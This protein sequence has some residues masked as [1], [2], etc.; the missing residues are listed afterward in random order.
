MCNV[1]FL[2]LLEMSLPGDAYLEA[3]A[4]TDNTVAR[5][6]LLERLIVLNLGS[7]HHLK[8]MVQAGGRGRDGRGKNGWN[9]TNECFLEMGSGGECSS[10]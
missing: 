8:R 3:Q 9:R 2:C 4:V 6:C 7:L 10:V 1:I 5:L